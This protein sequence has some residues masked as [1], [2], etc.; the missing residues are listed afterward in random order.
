MPAY[1][2]S[3]TNAARKDQVK[4]GAKA[5]SRS[6]TAHRNHIAAREC[7]GSRSKLNHFIQLRNAD[8]LDPGVHETITECKRR[9]FL[10]VN[11]K[12]TLQ[13]TL[14]GLHVVDQILSIRV[15]GEAV[16]DFNPGPNLLLVTK[17]L[18][19]GLSFH[20]P[21]SQCGGGRQN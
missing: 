5:E 4:A 17:D 15:A 11:K 1:A 9:P 18:H 2:D 12:N 6:W 20:E 13:V 3:C 8:V 14:E 19:G 21:A 16:D 7:R 10:A